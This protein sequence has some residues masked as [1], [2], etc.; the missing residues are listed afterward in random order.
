[1]TRLHHLATAVAAAVSAANTARGQVYTAGGTLTYT[2]T[3]D[4]GGDVPLASKKFPWP[5]LPYQADTGTGPRGAFDGVPASVM[6][7]RS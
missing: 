4:T 6:D 1:M 5:R 2:I 3:A 7:P